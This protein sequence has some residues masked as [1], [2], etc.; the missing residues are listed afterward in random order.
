MICTETPCSDS[1]PLNT[2]PT[3][4]LLDCSDAVDRLRLIVVF[5]CLSSL[6]FVFVSKDT[7]FGSCQS[8][9]TIMSSLSG[10]RGPLPTVEEVSEVFSDVIAMRCVELS[11]RQGDFRMNVCMFVSTGRG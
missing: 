7:V 1:S 8:H 6:N 2:P 11:W 10:Q 9:S 4:P 3:S 5:H